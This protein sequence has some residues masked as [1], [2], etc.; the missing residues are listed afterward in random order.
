MI[1]ATQ[2]KHSRINNDLLY[3]LQTLKINLTF[4]MEVDQIYFDG[5]KWGCPI[6]LGSRVGVEL[7]Q[8]RRI[9]I[10]KHGCLRSAQPSHLLWLKSKTQRL[11]L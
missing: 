6:W 3:N 7:M 9:S 2:N 4:V 10:G 8:G 5:M 11:R 1:K